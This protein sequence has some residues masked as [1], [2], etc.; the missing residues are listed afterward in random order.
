MHILVGIS[1]VDLNISHDNTCS[2]TTGDHPFIKH[3]SYATYG[4]A[5]QRHKTFVDNAAQKKIYKKHADASL[6]LVEK[7]CKGIK[8]SPFTKRSI[9]DGYDAS[10]RAVAKRSIP[11]TIQPPNPE[12]KDKS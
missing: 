9:K 3:N 12:E 11:K 4:F 6:Q 7:I 2:L 10:L 1:S 5:M 8:Q